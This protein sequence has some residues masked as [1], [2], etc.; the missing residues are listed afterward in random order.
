MIASGSTRAAW[1]WDAWARP[2]SS[3]VTGHE[4]V[5]R[6]VL[7]LERR[8][9]DAL[10][11]A[12]PTQSG[13]QRALARTRRGAG[14]EDAA[15]QLEWSVLSLTPAES[16]VAISRRILAAACTIGTARAAPDPSPRRMPR[17]ST[18]TSPSSS[19]DDRRSRLARTVADDQIVDDLGRERR[20]HERRGRGDDAV[21]DDRHPTCGRPDDEP[22]QRGDLEPAELGQHHEG[23]GA[24][25]E[26]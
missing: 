23:L 26:P 12:P 11:R 2:I 13:D 15:F 1:A 8:D 5:Q 17:S 16:K 22:A 24:R 7:S 19:E 25:S 18:G 3:P 20:R 6:H 14:D 4:G 10:R 21:H 9:R